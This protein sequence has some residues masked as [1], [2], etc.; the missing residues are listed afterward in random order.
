LHFSIAIQALDKHA[1][2]TFSFEGIMD[3]QLDGFSG[4]NVAGLIL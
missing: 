4:Q 2:V 1:L 3:L